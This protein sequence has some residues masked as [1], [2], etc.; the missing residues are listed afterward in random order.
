VTRQFATFVL[1]GG[2][3]ALVNWLSRIGLSAL[4]SLEFAVVLAYLAGMTTAY[5]LNRLFVFEK[6]GRSMREEYGRFALVNVVALAQVFVVTIGLGRFLFPLVGF[7]WHPHEVAHA[8]GVASPI[9][10][11]Y[12]GHRYFTFAAKRDG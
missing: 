6:S 1:A 12:A 8:I 9:L 4:M 7:G 5:G 10:T 11:S 2:I 3:A